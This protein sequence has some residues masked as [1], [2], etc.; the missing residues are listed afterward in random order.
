MINAR[1][2]LG[3]L[4]V[5][6]IF[7][8]GCST[9]DPSEGHSD[10]TSALAGQNSG[11]QC[12]VYNAPICGPGET[13]RTITT[14][15]GCQAPECHAACPIYNAP[16]CG[17]GETLRTV[18][19]PEGCQAPECHAACPVYNAPICGPGETLRTVTTPEGCQAPECHANN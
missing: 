18:T 11:G 16:I 2:C 17:P 1:R 15:D 9:S 4:V 14:P 10:Q 6:S 12:P 5:L 8:F 7:A 19:T 13:L 3:A